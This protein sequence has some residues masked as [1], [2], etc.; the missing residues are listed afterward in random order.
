MSVF[1]LL[2]GVLI[3]NSFSKH[4]SQLETSIKESSM[5]IVVYLLIEINLLVRAQLF[6]DG[7]K[8]LYTII[9]TYQ[10]KYPI[11]QQLFTTRKHMSSV[12]MTTVAERA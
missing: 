11:N 3:L 5:L 4:K 8:Y 2:C 10:Q 1:N 9:K 12:E 7:N 6:A